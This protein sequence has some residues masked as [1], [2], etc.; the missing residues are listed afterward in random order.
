M[1]ARENEVDH[2]LLM[3]D[4]VQALDQPAWQA[5]KREESQNEGEREKVP[6]RDPPASD[7]L[8]PARV[9]PLSLPFGRL[10]R[11][12]LLEL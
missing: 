4:H 7:L 11:R 12:L 3:K 9:S 1:K 10:P 8:A 5:V 2:S 6:Y